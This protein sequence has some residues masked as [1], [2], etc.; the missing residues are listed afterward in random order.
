MTAQIPRQ[1][2]PPPP[3]A[4]GVNRPSAPKSRGLAPLSSPSACHG[5][6]YR[7]FKPGK[8]GESGHAH[9]NR[10]TTSGQEQ[11]H[12]GLA[13]TRMLTGLNPHLS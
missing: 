7:P 8:L 4:L 6:E 9:Q 11:L 1:E 10:G 13:G 2:A 5:P 12:T 3:M